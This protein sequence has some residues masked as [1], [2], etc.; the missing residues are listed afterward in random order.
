[1]M[2]IFPNLQDKVIMWLVDIDYVIQFLGKYL[3]TSNISNL[4]DQIIAKKNIT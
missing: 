4:T 2:M 1:M 3:L